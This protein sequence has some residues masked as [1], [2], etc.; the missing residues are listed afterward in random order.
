MCGIIGC[1]TNDNAS[2]R[3]LDGLKFLEYRGYDSSGIACIFE[4]KIEIRKKLGKVRVLEHE[5]R[6]NP[7]YGDT[8][9]GHTRWATH[10]TPSDINAHPFLSNDGMF[11]AVHNGIIENYTALKTFLIEKNFVFDSE[12]DSE[13]IPN[14]IQYCYKKDTEQA[15]T[16]AVK[17]LKG[18]FAIAVISARE[19]RRI[20]A[21][22]KDNPMVVGCDGELCAVC[23]DTAGLQT[24]LSSAVILDNRRIAVVSPEGVVVKDFDGNAVP[25]SVTALEK[26]P[27]KYDFCDCRMIKEIDEI[28]EALSRALKSYDCEKLMPYLKNTRRICFIGCGTALH[29]CMEAKYILRKLAPKLDAYAEPASEFLFTEYDFEN[30]LTVAVSQSGETADT[31]GA[32]RKV[33][34]RGGKVIAVCN[35]PSSSLSRE[36]DTVVNTAAGLEIAVA[37]TKA[38]NCQIALLTALCLDAALYSGSITPCLYSAYRDSMQSLPTAAA[39]A[40]LRRD[41]ISEFAKKYASSKSVF[42]IGRGADFYVACEGSLKL[43]EISYINSEAYAGGELKHGTLAL[44]E[45]GVIVVAIVTQSETLK[46]SVNNIIEVKSR[47]A[48]VLT[49]TQFDDADLNAVSDYTVKIPPSDDLLSPPV[50]VIPTQLLAY[51]IAKEKG[52]DIDKPRNLAKSVTVE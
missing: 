13:I 30:T 38:Y 15:I 14:L 40:L 1:V 41:K 46:K 51:F 31:L 45:K 21:V 18:S 33:R 20:F 16:D 6:F 36:A 12:T 44:M 17:V 24:L 26:P 47:G 2:K 27:E 5:L 52:C 7:M 3:V 32:V 23:S 11:A 19:P 29:A 39:K 48:T 25:F 4:K 34:E 49:V 10:G 37:S 50:S 43:K 42:Y 28:P 9:I 35:T 22:K 8:A